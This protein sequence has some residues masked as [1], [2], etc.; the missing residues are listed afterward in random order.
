ME[1]QPPVDDYVDGEHFW[2]YRGS[3]QAAKFD[4]ACD[5]CGEQVDLDD[6]MGLMLSTCEDPACSVART[7]RE[8]GEGAWVYVALCADSSHASGRCVSER[9]I[10]ALTEY[11]NANLKNPNKR[12]IVVPCRE[13]SDIDTC[14]GI[15]MADTG[16]T[17]FY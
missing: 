5:S 11:F 9:G 4:L 1:A 16:L 12:I 7:A 6:L 17:E 3:Y 10:Q 8:A 15:V 14:E 13:C 2:T